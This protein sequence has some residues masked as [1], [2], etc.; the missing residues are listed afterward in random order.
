MVPVVAVTNLLETLES[1]AQGP[2]DTRCL[3][4]QEIAT[5]LVVVPPVGNRIFMPAHPVADDHLLRRR[6]VVIRMRDALSL[7]LAVVTTLLPPTTTVMAV[8]HHLAALALQLGLETRRLVVVRLLPIAREEVPLMGQE[9]EEEEEEVVVVV[10]AA[11]EPP[12]A[13]RCPL[14]TAPRSTATPGG[15]TLW[16]KLALAT[17]LLQGLKRPSRTRTIMGHGWDPKARR[18]QQRP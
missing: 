1:L 11:L 6:A 8:A 14:S 2:I 7:A 4:P 15:K 16:S 3:L 10:V 13:T 18:L 9:R 5:I 12:D 17:P